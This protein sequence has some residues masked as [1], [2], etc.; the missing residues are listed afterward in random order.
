MAVFYSGPNA[1][2]SGT[3]LKSVQLDVSMIPDFYLKT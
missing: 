3:D 1:E 2:L